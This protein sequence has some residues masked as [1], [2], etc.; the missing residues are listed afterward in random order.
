MQILQQ[1]EYEYCR[2][3]LSEFVKG[4]FKIVSPNDVY[5]HSWYIDLI[6]EHLMNCYERKTTKLI[7]NIPPRHMK[8]I[9]VNIA[10]PAWLL[11]KNPTENILTATYSLKL[12][13]THSLSFNRLMAS[14]WYKSIFPGTRVERE[15][16]EFMATT[17][18]GSR[19]A[20][21]VGGQLTGAGGS[22]II[23]DDPLNAI[24]ATSQ[25]KRDQVNEWFGFSLSSRKN[26]EDAVIA[27]VAQRLHENDLCGYLLKQ[28]SWE[29]LCLAA[30]AER[31]ER[32]EINSKTF[33]RREGELLCRERLGYDFFDEQRKQLGSYGFAGQYQQRPVPMGGGEFKKSWIQY[34]DG[35]LD[36]EKYTKFLC[37]D[38]ANSKKKTSDY[39]A[40]SILGLGGDG[41]IY[42]LDLYRDRLNLHE[43]EDLVFK[44]HAKYKPKYVLYEQYGM[45]AD[46]EYLRNQMNYR[47]Y[48]FP[49]REVGGKLSKEDRIRRL[50]PYFVDEKV[51]LPRTLLRADTDGKMHDLIQA[52]VEEELAVFPVGEHDD[53]IDSMS[54]IF[55]IFNGGALVFPKDRLLDAGQLINP[56]V[57]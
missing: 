42:L 57:K 36:Y 13:R 3:S 31:D 4:A 56:R 41:N 46:V 23:I 15:S 29:N 40:I 39:T 51:W 55:D 47:N 24:D 21:T 53:M 26:R 2:R 52:L 25:L 30:I 10:F 8:S 20:T 43:R 34:Y 14:D 16:M 35:V 27:I 38:P 50:A 11:G 19:F 22:Y 17:A 9:I 1:Y 28:G 6:C 32:Y 45:Q 33:S 44:L 7:V 49:I 12:L 54:R 48:R 18:G 5:I 37:V